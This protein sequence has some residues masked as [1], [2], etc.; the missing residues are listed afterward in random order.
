MAQ[1]VRDR[2]GRLDMVCSLVE[3]DQP[4]KAGVASL[5]RIVPDPPPA[6]P[7]AVDRLLGLTGYAGPSTISFIGSGGRWM[8]HDVNLRLGSSVGLVMRGGLDMPRRAVEVALGLPAGAPPRPRPYRYARLDGELSALADAVR[9]R[10]PGES[11]AGIAAS[12]TRV[13]LGPGG[14]VDPTPSSRSSG[15]AW[16]PPAAGRSR[17]GRARPP[18]AALGCDERR[19]PFRSRRSARSWRSRPP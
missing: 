2:D 7:A 13:A 11:P 4:R 12:L 8:V 17:G 10:T 19:R 15:R 3:R 1:S 16:R 5:M 9:H 6:V 18:A 14:M